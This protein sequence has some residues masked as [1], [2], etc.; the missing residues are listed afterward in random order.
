MFDMS[1]VSS[2]NRK[3]RSERTGKVFTIRHRMTS[4]SSNIVCHLYCDTCSHTQYIRE[5]KNSLRTTI[6]TQTQ[7]LMS[8]ELSPTYRTTHLFLQIE[9]VHTADTEKR[10]E[11]ESFWIWK[12][13][14]LFL[15]GI[16]CNSSPLFRAAPLTHPH[17]PSLGLIISAGAIQRYG[18]QLSSNQHLFSAPWT[19]MRRN[20]LVSVQM[21]PS[22]EYH[23]PLTHCSHLELNI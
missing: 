12:M 23:L 1:A 22:L 19:T 14:T 9:K 16:I 21:Q 11:R 6:S 5:T 8:P 3:F 20:K 15:L 4:D 10:Q 13:R 18:L 2:G 17:L 7:A